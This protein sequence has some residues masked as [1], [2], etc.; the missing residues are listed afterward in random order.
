MCIIVGHNQTTKDYIITLG[1]AVR[2]YDTDVLSARH[3]YRI[4]VAVGSDLARPRL[5][6]LRVDTI[7]DLYGR[8][9]AFHGTGSSHTLL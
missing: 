3:V 4:C 2:P 8:Q 6:Q 9:P 1:S 5:V 7:Q